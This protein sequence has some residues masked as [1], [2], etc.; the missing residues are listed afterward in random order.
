MDVLCKPDMVALEFV[1]VL[2]MGEINLA[3]AVL[4]LDK[5][6]SR[7]GSLPVPAPEVDTLGAAL[8]LLELTMVGDFSG[9][10]GAFAALDVPAVPLLR[11]AAVWWWSSWSSLR[12][13]LLKNQ[14]KSALSEA[15][16][17]YDSSSSNRFLSL[18]CCIA[19]ESFV[20]I[21][22]VCVFRK[23]MEWGSGCRWMQT[24][25][26]AG[27]WK[28]ARN[29]LWGMDVGCRV[30]GDNWTLLSCS[31]TQNGLA[32]TL[33]APV[34]LPDGPLLENHPSRPSV[35]ASRP[36]HMPY[37]TMPCHHPPPPGGHV[38]QQWS[39]QASR[40]RAGCRLRK[41]GTAKIGGEAK[42]G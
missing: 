23:G 10:T 17:T 25:T 8:L 14:S 3:S 16:F 27:S 37:H 18:S 21:L 31:R 5:E 39:R 30:C 2:E 9:D 33:P 19:F 42:T 20:D 32:A 22:R 15:D 7:L 28:L 1:E 11:A 34:R 12:D 35:Q 36:Y 6:T 26:D 41:T 29:V 4:L 24:K 38:P 13:W 40:S